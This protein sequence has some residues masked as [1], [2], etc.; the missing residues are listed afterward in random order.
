MTTKFCETT[1]KETEHEISEAHS[2]LQLN[3]S[4]SE[5]SNIKEQ[6]NK[7]QELAIQHLR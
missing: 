2:K 4:S 7:N 5:Y 6:V 1:I 3:L